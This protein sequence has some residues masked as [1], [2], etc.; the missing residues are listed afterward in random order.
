LLGLLMTCQVI[1]IIGVIVLI[2]RPIMMSDFALT[3]AYGEQVG[4]RADRAAVIA[5]SQCQR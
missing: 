4:A 5:G 1:A 2:G 3:R